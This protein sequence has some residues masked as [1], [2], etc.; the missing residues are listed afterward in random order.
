MS[1]TAPTTLFSETHRLPQQLS[2]TISQ[3]SISL[4]DHLHYSCQPIY[5]VNVCKQRLQS[6]ATSALELY[7]HRL[8]PFLSVGD[9]NRTPYP[10]PKSGRHVKFQRKGSRIITIS[11]NN[12]SH[13]I[14]V[15]ANSTLRFP[16]AS[17]TLALLE[18]D[19]KR[20]SIPAMTYDFM[21]S[22]KPPLQAFR[23]C[24]STALKH[25]ALSSR[26]PSAMK[27]GGAGLDRVSRRL[28][29]LGA[30]GPMERLP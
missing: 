26:P 9:T 20:L 23:I 13:N 24:H 16:H 10:L 11:E 4:I 1:S 12:C 5:R 25:D 14:N 3:S 30:F 19:G 28:Q 27:S 22:S 29:S 8:S 15:H 18:E 17:P 6:R 2:S 21:T 7:E